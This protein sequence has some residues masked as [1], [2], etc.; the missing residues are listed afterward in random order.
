MRSALLAIKP[1]RENNW[2]WNTLESPPG[3]N[4]VTPS[5]DIVTRSGSDAARDSRCDTRGMLLESLPACF[6]AS[7]AIGRSLLHTMSRAARASPP[8]RNE[9]DASD[10]GSETLIDDEYGVL[11]LTALRTLR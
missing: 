5:R 3:L 4:I 7:L 1:R 8:M 6:T 2:G 9:F 11:Y 10:F